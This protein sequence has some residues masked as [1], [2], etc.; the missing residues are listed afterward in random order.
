MEPIERIRPAVSKDNRDRI[1]VLPVLV[2]KMDANTV[3]FGTELIKSIK[4]CLLNTPVVLILPVIYQT[5]QVV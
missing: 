3:N 2:N 4:F 1:R 5:F